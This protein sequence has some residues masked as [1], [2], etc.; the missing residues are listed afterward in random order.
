MSYSLKMFDPKP[1]IIALS[2]SEYESIVMHS[3]DFV[4][5]VYVRQGRGLSLVGQKYVKVGKGDLFVIADKN[6]SHS[7]QPIESDEPLDMINILF[8]FEYFDIDWTVFNPLKVVSMSENPEA[9]RI[10]FRI[11]DEYRQKRNYYEK[12]TYSLAMYLL[13]FLMRQ[14]Y[15]PQGG[16]TGKNEQNF[17]IDGYIEKA[18]AFIHNNYDKCITVDDIAAECGLCKAYLQRIFKNNRNTTVKEYLIKYRIEQGCKLLLNTSY[19]VSVISEMVGFFSIKYFY[20][21]FK[22]IVGV[23]PAAY[24]QDNGGI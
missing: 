1:G 2:C 19:S 6:I 4:E 13:Y 12:I 18:V 11:F 5:I 9:E 3:H 7:V 8:P 23:T 15:C 24:R 22:E 16:R 14:F 20:L 21:K 17:Q 10:I